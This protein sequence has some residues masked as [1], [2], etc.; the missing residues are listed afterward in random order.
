[1]SESQDIII[2]MTALFEAFWANESFHPLLKPEMYASFG[3]GFRAGYKCG[4]DDVIEALKKRE[5]SK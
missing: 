2:R 5:A 3:C 1:M 4:S